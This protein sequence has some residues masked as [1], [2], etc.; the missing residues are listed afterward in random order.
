MLTWGKRKFDLWLDVLQLTAKVGLL[1]RVM[2]S[3]AENLAPELR[4]VLSQL[5]EV[6]IA[7]VTVGAPPDANPF[8]GRLLPQRRPFLDRN[9]NL[10]LRSPISPPRMA[11]GSSLSMVRR[12]RAAATSGSSSHTA[13]CGWASRPIVRCEYSRRRSRWA[14][15]PGAH[16]I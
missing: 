12:V 8:D 2:E 1:R 4:T 3:L 14:V 10:A 7:L 11:H 5:P 9:Q 16:W 6:D 13:V 15:M